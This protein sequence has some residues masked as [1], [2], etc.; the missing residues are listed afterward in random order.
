MGHVDVNDLNVSRPPPVRS[1]WKL[2]GFG[3][4]VEVKTFL[5]ADLKERTLRLNVSKL[6]NGF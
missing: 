5:V 6:F 4:T 2:F 3:S 1:P